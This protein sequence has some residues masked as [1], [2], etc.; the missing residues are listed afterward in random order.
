MDY[1]LGSLFS[2]IGGMDLGLVEAG[3]KLDF[4][5]ENNTYCRKVLKK[6]Y[7]DVPLHPDIKQVKW[8]LK[9][10]PVFLLA[11]GPPCQP[12]SLAGN[13]LGD[14]DERW[15]WPE[16]IKLIEIG[17]PQ[18]VLMENPP[19]ILTK[20]MNYVLSELARIGY[21]AEWATIPAAFFNAPHRRERVFI[22]CYPGGF[23]CEKPRVFYEESN[24]APRDRWLPEPDIP[25]VDDGTPYRVDRT[26]AIGNAVVPQVSAW[27][28]KRII[29]WSEENL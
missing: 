25:R 2:G 5:C 19:G 7:P 23:R 10:N 16:F 27:I 21:D 3:F 11:G 6:H 17:H 8:Y 20:G 24:P 12:V 14:K 9:D 4:L 13:R 29:N 22:I 18:F 26:T 1:T 28:G 15:L